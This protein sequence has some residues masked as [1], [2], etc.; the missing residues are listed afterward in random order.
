VT[1]AADGRLTKKQTEWVER[2]LPK[3][4]ILARSVH[5]MIGEISVDEL[6]SA[7]HE[8]LIQAALRYDPTIGVP[9]VAFAHYRIRGAM[10]D[11]ARAIRP[12]FRKQQR[13]LAALQATQSL[14][15]QA[16]QR[17]HGVTAQDKRTLEQRVAAA[18]E[19]VVQATA[20]VLLAR[21]QRDDPEATPSRERDIETS[22]IDAQTH[23]TLRMLIDKC[24]E[25]ERAL[26][27][28]LYRRGLN[29]HEY[30]REAGMSVSTVSRYHAK[31]VARLG[32]ELR[33]RGH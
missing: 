24:S 29:M 27:E 10:I 9:F 2:T 13:A 7:G 6:E 20:A 5:R 18:A 16:A 26:I 11:A 23:D 1:K 33:A 22:L 8:G 25:D 32:S 15:E 19:L 17:E 3:V 21:N 4:R 31:L 30:A 12:E 28:A 14:L